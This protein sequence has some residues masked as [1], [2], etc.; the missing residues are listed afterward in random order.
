MGTQQAKT[1]VGTQKNTNDVTTQQ[2]VNGVLHLIHQGVFR[3]G[4]PIREIELC[5]R[6]KVSRTPV[7]E[8]LRL[9]QNNG[10]VEYIPRCGVQVVDLTE[11]DLAYIT[12]TRTVLEVLSAREAALCITPEQVEELRRI[13]RELL[14]QKETGLGGK[15]DGS[16]HMMIARFSGNPC[17][18]EYIRNL[19]M[20]QALFA[21][22][23]PMQPQ[24]IVCAYEEHEA[25]IRGLE[26]QDPELAA[27]QAH[28][29]FHTSQRSL[30]NKLH[31]YLKA[32]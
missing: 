27:M 8:A 16:F 11:Q 1:P 4:T 19:L 3:P 28:I 10:V 12:D 25:I 30:Q 20:R 24:R 7:R 15:L 6:F 5:K 26:L 18:V 23:I 31:K 21:S 9:L 32:K 29:H 17:L 22:T 2:I 13:N 14:A